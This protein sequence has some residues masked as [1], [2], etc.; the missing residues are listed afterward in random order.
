MAE[1]AETMGES[2]GSEVNTQQTTETV[3]GGPPRRG[4]LSVLKVSQLLLQAIAAHKGLT[5]AALKKELGNAGY[6]V[7]RKYGH[8]LHEGSS[9]RV[10]GTLLRVSGSNAAGCFRVWKITK[11][12]R[13]PGR[14]S[15]EEGVRSPRRTPLQTRSPR[16]RCGRRRAAKKAQEVW[17]QSLRAY[18]RMRRIKPRA[19]E[20]VSSRAK[21]EGRAKA[22]DEGRGRTEKED[23]RPRTPD[24]KRPRS[25]PRKAKKQAPEKPVKRTMQKPTSVK[26]NRASKRQGKTHD[27]R[28][29]R[30]KTSIKSE[31]PQNAAGNP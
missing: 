17:R 4:P 30:T 13:K 10:K 5:L 16:R 26:T 24:E 12:K 20:P 11:S 7:C 1:G 6:R 22:V 2:Q 21:E 15:L 9:S 27:P 8:H 28:A 25:K 18:M 14:Q 3:L 29:A 31:G 23:I 19:R